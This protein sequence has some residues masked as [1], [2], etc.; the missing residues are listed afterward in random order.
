MTKLSTLPPRPGDLRPALPSSAP[1]GLVEGLWLLCCSPACSPPLRPRIR[2][3]RVRVLGPGLRN[4]WPAGPSAFSCQKHKAAR[5]EGRPPG[6]AREFST[7]LF[8]FTLRSFESPAP[9]K[10]GH[11]PRLCH[12]LF[13]YPHL[14]CWQSH[15][16]TSH[17]LPHQPPSR[18]LWVAW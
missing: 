8:L 10:S 17:P 16:V 2:Y 7:N 18:G 4:E 1:P 14:C 5:Q 9:Q 11:L 12:Q 13:P 15:A 6:W 3:Q